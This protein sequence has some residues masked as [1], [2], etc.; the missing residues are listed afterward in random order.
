MFIFSFD[1]V[2]CQNVTKTWSLLST[3]SS[4]TPRG[5]SL[6]FSSEKVLSLSSSRFCRELTNVNMSME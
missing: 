1:S 4:P 2:L 3:W 6:V 5:G